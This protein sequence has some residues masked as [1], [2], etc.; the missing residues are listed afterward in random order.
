MA[1]FC[2]KCGR[3]LPDDGIC[4]CT[5]EQPQQ[6]PSQPVPEYVTPQYST[7]PSILGKAVSS[8]LK[9]LPNLWRGFFRDPVGTTRL[10]TEKRDFA[11]GLMMLAFSVFF[12]LIGT[13]LFGLIHLK[14][15]TYFSFSDFAGRWIC[16]SFLAPISAFVIQA[17]LLAILSAIAR[18]QAD[19]L[20]ILAATGVSSIF[21]ALLLFVSIFAGM[22]SPAVFEILAVLMMAAWAVTF[23]MNVFQ[24]LG[25]RLNTVNILLLIAGLALAFYVIVLLLT[26][27]VYDGAV[28]TLL[29]NLEIFAGLGELSDWIW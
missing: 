2:T 20:G 6:A 13:L 1:G 5:L 29:G 23:F 25:I 8:T 24:V 16:V 27:L 28:K 4:P 26:W 12:T 9:N 21:S 18:T 14:D 19:F 17:G 3:P 10:A 22:I 7:Q 15:V 11:S